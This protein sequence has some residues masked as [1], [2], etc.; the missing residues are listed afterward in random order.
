MLVPT[1][2]LL[3]V[4]LARVA[5]NQHPFLHNH[6]PSKTA[7]YDSGLF[8]PFG[9][10]SALSATEY[11]T[12]VHPAFPLHSVRIKPSSFCDGTVRRVR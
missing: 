5:A 4:G 9:D 10:L 12:L 8:T 6:G 2:V 11:T 3:A 1:S 7:T